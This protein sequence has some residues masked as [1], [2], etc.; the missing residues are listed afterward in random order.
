MPHEWFNRE[1][2]FLFN[3]V[4]F[5]DTYYVNAI[6]YPKRVTTMILVSNEKITLST[7]YIDTYFPQ[8]SL[9]QKIQQNLFSTIPTFL[10]LAN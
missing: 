10:F 4:L 1:I 6:F 8:I 5:T 2:L 7:V 9:A 3:Q